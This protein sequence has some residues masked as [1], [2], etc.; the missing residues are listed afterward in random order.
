[1][2]STSGCGYSSACS[3]LLA[4]G[5]TSRSTKR[6]T[7]SITWA[8]TARRSSTAAPAMHAKF[9]MFVPAVQ[10]RALNCTVAVTTVVA[11]MLVSRSL[12][13]A[14][15]GALLVSATAWARAPEPAHPGHETEV[16]TGGEET[17]QG[18]TPRRPALAYWKLRLTVR[19]PSTERPVRVGVLVPLSDGR[20]D[21]LGR[22]AAAPGFHFR[23]SEAPPNLRA[24]WAAERATATALTYDLALR[25]AEPT[26]PPIPAE[27]VAA[28]PHPPDGE[29]ALAPT[30]HIQSDAPEVRRRA[31][32]IVGRATRLDEVIWSLYQ[33]TAAFVP[34]ADPPGAQDAVTVLAARRGT[35]L[36][37]ARALTALLQAVGV[38]ARL[39]GGLRLGSTPEKRA[40][41]SWVEAWTGSEWVPFD[42]AGGYFGTLPTSYL[43]LYRG[44][45]PLIVHTA[46]L[47]VDYGFAIRQATRRAVEEGE[48]EEDVAL[49]A[50]R[51]PVVRGAG[52]QPVETHSTY[53]SEP[54]ASV[55]LI[56]DQSVPEAVTDR[57]LG[58]AHDAAINCVLLTARFES[59][60]FRES[61]LER[62]V[63]TNLP[64]I[65]QAHVVLVA[66]ADD[67]GLYALLGL[68]ERNVRLD[69]ARIIAAG[70]M[71]RPAALMLGSL[72]YHLIHPGE[73]VLVNHRADLLP[74]WEL[75]RANLI[76]GTPMAEE[77]RRWNIDALVLGEAGARLPAWRRPLMHLWARAV[78]AQVPL[79]ALTLILILPI[80]A[81]LVVVARIV[82]GLETFGMF[83]PVIVSLAFITTGLQWGLVIFVVIVGLGVLLRAGL[84]RL[85]L[86]AVSRLA[87][88]IALVSA[89]MGGLTLLGA[90]LGIGPLL[91]ISIFPMVIMSNVI[92][93]F[94]ASQVELGTAEA[95]RMTLATLFLSVACYLVVDQAGLQSLVLAF[96]EILLV[97]VAFDAVLGK[98]RGVRL[99]EYVRFFRAVRHGHAETGAVSPAEAR[100]S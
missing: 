27:P 34:A 10:P 64:L 32:R 55:V 30:R 37:R 76:D 13:T 2:R 42:P 87:I 60:Y 51:R 12:R 85:R 17:A 16:F 21:V 93:N 99:L 44:D 63:A 61:Y 7:V 39:V 54:V 29:A 20:Q 72:L 94:A 78:R 47:D 79:S 43:A 22:R 80:I 36:G 90:V 100:R 97:T 3:Y 48:E 33:Y 38:P 6:R 18:A 1:M 70:A 41:N 67:A 31:Q 68:G 75:A 58:E 69:D 81:S 9:T 95:L 86:Q 45:L 77:A 92:E 88:L 65:R 57:I 96:P 4:T 23:E 26:A 73:V 25:I 53:V 98:W 89:V 59:R 8:V 28:L 14:V 15:L 62:L 83:G 46:G 66:T 19:V 52:R 91:N 84:Q 5:I 35:S 24:E 11:F 50:G 56:A 74:L 49:T 40:T 71:G 82:V